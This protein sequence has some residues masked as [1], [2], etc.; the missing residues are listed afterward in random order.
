LYTALRRFTVFGGVGVPPGLNPQDVCGIM[1]ALQA[2]GVACGD[3]KKTK[4]NFKVKKKNVKETL[5]GR[6]LF[7]HSLW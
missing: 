3:F 6:S 7:D 1:D 5:G 2:I 4:K